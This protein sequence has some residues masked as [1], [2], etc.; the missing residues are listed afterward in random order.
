ML[1]R[2]LGVHSNQIHVSEH[3]Q[4]FYTEFKKKKIKI[5]I[6]IIVFSIKL[7]LNISTCLFMIYLFFKNLQPQ[8]T[9]VIKI[10]HHKK[11]QWVIS[12]M[13]NAMTQFV[14]VSFDKWASSTQKPKRVNHRAN[15]FFLFGPKKL[16]VT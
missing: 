12:N 8:Q 14:S 4:I 3:H 11:V 15:I 10:I 2:K 16:A 7:I 13:N 5:V 6:G 1:T 9:N